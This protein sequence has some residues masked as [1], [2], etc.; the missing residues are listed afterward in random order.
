[1]R[2]NEARS[3]FKFVVFCLKIVK[4]NKA[5]NFSYRGARKI[6]LV[7]LPRFWGSENLIK[8]FLTA[9]NNYVM[10]KFKMAATPNAIL[11]TLL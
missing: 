9:S 4:Y 11:L 1:M 3:I 10:L 5:H 8:A 7:C 2:C 6:A